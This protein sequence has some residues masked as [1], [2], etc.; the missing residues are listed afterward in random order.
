MGAV[1]QCVPHAQCGGVDQPD[2]VARV[3]QIDGLAV[4]SEDL[5]GVLGG[6]R[7][8]GLGV[9]HHRTAFEDPRADRMNAS[10]SR[11]LASIPDWTLNTTPL[12]G[13]SN[14]R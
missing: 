7:L 2:D 14:A 1:V 10:R 12:K 5:L 9:R 6:E 13:A 3:G 11:C 8:A 4:A